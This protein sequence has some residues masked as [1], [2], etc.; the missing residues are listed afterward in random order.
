MTAHPSWKA[1]G[2]SRSRTC[3]KQAA[4]SAR[5]RRNRLDRAVADAAEAV[6]RSMTVPE[7]RTIRYRAIAHLK[8]PY[9]VFSA[10]FYTPPANSRPNSE[11]YF[12][13]GSYGTYGR[14]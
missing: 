1:A 12:I 6:D 5:K 14:W 10:S 4:A 13:P 11:G 3:P 8:T 7:L 2:E 9:T